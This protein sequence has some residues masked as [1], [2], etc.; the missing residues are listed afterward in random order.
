MSQISSPV[1]VC[2]AWGGGVV[3]A[4]VSFLAETDSQRHRKRHADY[5][6]LIRGFKW[7]SQGEK[8]DERNL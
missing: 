7:K 1:C 4:K 8:R 2:S 3:G 5:S 6:D